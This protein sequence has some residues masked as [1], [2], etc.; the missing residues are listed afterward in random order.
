MLKVELTI[1]HEGYRLG[2][3]PAFA[4]DSVCEVSLTS[5]P[6]RFQISRNGD[7]HQ[8]VSRSDTSGNEPSSAT[9]VSR[10]GELFCRD[11]PRVAECW[12]ACPT[13]GGASITPKFYSARLRSSIYTPIRRHFKPFS[14]QVEIEGPTDRK[15]RHWSST[16]RAL[17]IPLHDG[18]QPE[19]GPDFCQAGE[20]ECG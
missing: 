20:R 5:G 2:S 4:H 3:M 16:K 19:S 11:L 6:N 10:F 14:T 17:V 9:A 18:F 15:D 12:T 7:W 13:L 1:S 8:A